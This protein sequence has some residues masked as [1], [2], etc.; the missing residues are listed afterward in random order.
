MGF[1]VTYAIKGYYNKIPFEVRDRALLRTLLI[2]SLCL[3]PP[4]FGRALPLPSAFAVLCVCLVPCC[5]WRFG[6]PLVR[7]PS[8]LLGVGCPYVW[9]KVLFEFLHNDK[10]QERF[11][12]PSI[13]KINAVQLQCWSCG[14]Q[15]LLFVSFDTSQ[16]AEPCC[17]Y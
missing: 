4:P 6:F 17:V 13:L 7:C 11:W 10:F 8:A 2:A 16:L 14:I 1:V 15:L 9:G 5:P 12:L 3:S